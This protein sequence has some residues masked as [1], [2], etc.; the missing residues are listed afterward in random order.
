MVVTTKQGLRNTANT[1]NVNA[2]AGVQNWSEFADVLT[3]SYDYQR[4]RD[5]AEMNRYKSAAITANILEKY[6]IG[7]EP[8]FDKSFDWKNYIIK[9]N[10]PLNS[11]NIN[12]TRKYC[13]IKKI[14]T[15]FEPKGKQKIQN[16]EQNK[17][18]RS[19]LKK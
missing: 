9:K 19:V 3:N 14:T 16:I 17:T 6:R 18:M 12:F 13:R 7:T 4:Y 11:V 1:T 15:N 2:Y 10:A 5:E 8:G